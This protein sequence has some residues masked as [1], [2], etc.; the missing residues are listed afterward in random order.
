MSETK[1]HFVKDGQRIPFCDFLKREKRSRGLT[2]KALGQ[3][4]GTSI[5]DTYAL[6][7]ANGRPNDP[8]QQK[9]LRII[10]SLGY[11]AG[12]FEI[13]RLVGQERA[14]PPHEYRMYLRRL[15]DSILE[16]TR[17]NLVEGVRPQK[18]STTAVKAFL[19]DHFYRLY[20]LGHDN[21]QKLYKDLV[22]LDAK[23]RSIELQH[24]DEGGRGAP[25]RLQEFESDVIESALL[26][27]LS[28]KSL[29]TSDRLPKGTVSH[30]T[31]KLNEILEGRGMPPR[32]LGSMIYHVDRIWRNTRK[33]ISQTRGSPRSST[34]RN[35]KLLDEQLN[36][37]QDTRDAEPE[38]RALADA[39][40]ETEDLTKKRSNFNKYAAAGHNN[41]V[42]FLMDPKNYER[43][44]GRD[45]SLFFVDFPTG[46]VAEDLLAVFKEKIA[47]LEAEQESFP[48]EA[49]VLGFVEGW[50]RC[51]MIF[52]KRGGGFVVVEVKQHA[53]D[54]PD[55]YKNGTKACQQL[56][57]YAAILLDNIIRHNLDKTAQPSYEPVKESVEGYLAAYEIAPYFIDHL[58][59]A[60]NRRPIVISREEV[61]AYIA[62][63]RSRSRTTT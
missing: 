25:R 35:T 49:D 62:Q 41:L 29:P 39:I 43:H 26:K 30:V 57:G 21:M 20:G 54:K 12:D 37:L 59:R 52:R 14:L 40:V 11:S 4:C 13:D 36:V 34:E 32:S 17:K 19:S 48:D 63:L 46:D 55:G 2:W 24:I 58:N 6:A 23:Y 7:M 42:L 22:E 47:L 31:D 53:I 3:I 27:H 60:G 56:S 33:R 38:L 28:G 15:G 16:Q 44:I 51:D 9:F 50:L 61:D 18:L 8:P 5:I 45:L 1:I 10:R